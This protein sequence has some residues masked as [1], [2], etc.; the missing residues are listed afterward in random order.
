[1]S[2]PNLLI[3]KR[4]ESRHLQWWP[5]WMWSTHGHWQDS[6]TGSYLRHGIEGALGVLIILL[7]ASYWRPQTHA[8]A[9]IVPPASAK[10][11]VVAPADMANTIVTAHLFGQAP[12]RTPALSSTTQSITVDG[13]VYAPQ[14]QDSVALLTLDGKADLYKVGELLTDG[15]KIIAIDASDVQLAANGVIRRVALAQYGSADSVGPA[16]YAALLS[17]VGLSSPD[18]VDGRQNSPGA[19]AEASVT[20]SAEQSFPSEAVRVMNGGPWSSAGIVHISANATPLE[21]LQA[22]R[23]QLIHPH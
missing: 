3:R 6:R 20:D 11:T 8:A 7:L 10:N 23:A 13:I 18:S 22:L 1:M 5:T 19:L 16:A 2:L 14:P 12:A 21:E 15:E 9:A 4:W 17:G